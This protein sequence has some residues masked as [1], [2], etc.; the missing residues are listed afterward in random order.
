MRTFLMTALFAVASHAYAECR[1]LDPE[2]EETFAG[3]CVDGLA[4]GRGR[5]TGVAEYHGEFR[6]GRKHGQ[7]VKTWPNGDRY[8]GD[9]YEDRFEGFG[10]YLFGRG[11]W[12]GER[13]E[14]DFAGGR[15]HGHGVYRWPTGDVYTGPWRE[16]VAVG[17]PTP[18]MRA[19]AKFRDEAR[20]AVAHPGQ[21]VCRA[22]P[23]GI[24]HSDWVRGVVVA[25]S[26]DKVAVRIE[27]LG[28]GA[29]ALAAQVRA[30]ETL[31]D[32]PSAW[33]PCFSPQP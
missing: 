26:E 12:A 13:Y 8:E 14:G 15:R 21:A 32:D 2:L 27:D 20:A 3:R 17:S 25:A 18:M 31:W 9:F 11:P 10:R 30:G 5:A 4:E 7:G 28:S 22:E 16:D 19:Q 1:V 6:A 33:T 24:A 23:V 29:N